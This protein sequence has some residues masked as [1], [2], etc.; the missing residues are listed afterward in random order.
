[1]VLRHDTTS[2]YDAALRSGFA[3]AAANGYDVVVSMDADGQHDPGILDAVVSPVRDGEVSMALGVRPQPARISERVFGWYSRLRFGVP[4]PLCGVKAF[5]V[6]IYNRHEE[7]M[8]AD[9]IG[10]GLAL[11]ALRAGVR[12]ALIV[13]PIHAREDKSRFG[14]GVRPNARIL[15]VLLVAI[16]RDLGASCRSPWPSRPRAP[17]VPRADRS[18]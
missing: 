8:A 5:S 17:E 1:M 4:D 18:P 9:T 15:R 11:A 13:V 6:G 7:S 2:G 12:P 16:L 3:W 10:T 14:S